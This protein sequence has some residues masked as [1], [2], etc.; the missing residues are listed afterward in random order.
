MWL[1]SET[2]KE[3]ASNTTLTEYDYDVDG[4][5]QLRM[6]D[7]VQQHTLKVKVWLCMRCDSA[8]VPVHTSYTYVLLL[9]SV[10][11][12]QHFK[13]TYIYIH[14]YE[15]NTLAIYMSWIWFDLMHDFVI[16]WMIFKNNNTNFIRNSC[17]SIFKQHV[18]SKWIVN[19]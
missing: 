13:H 2:V 1:T 18:Y 5:W 11:R 12:K 9:L 14:Y 17:F 19:F 10:W 15:V 16:K 7:C 8:C 4:I 3:W 6:T